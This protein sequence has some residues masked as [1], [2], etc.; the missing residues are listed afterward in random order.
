MRQIRLAYA[1]GV[2]RR[3]LSPV[4]E[5]ACR[6]ELSALSLERGLGEVLDI[7]GASIGKGYVVVS[8]PRRFLDRLEV[9]E[10][11]ASRWPAL[12]AACALVAPLA[13]PGMPG[14]IARPAL[15][16]SAPRS[17]PGAVRRR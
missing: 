10:F 9:V 8:S 14:M 6:D 1:Y 5:S 15:R 11:E 13:L 16:Q 2:H 3:Q 7:H 12:S 4:V 17:A